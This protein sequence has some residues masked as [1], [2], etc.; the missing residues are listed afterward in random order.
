MLID[1][2]A[3]KNNVSVYSKKSICEHYENESVW[4]ICGEFWEK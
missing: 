3:D 1:A 4:Q 2:G